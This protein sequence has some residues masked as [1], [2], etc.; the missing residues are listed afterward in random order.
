MYKYFEKYH[1]VDAGLLLLRLGLAA[2]FI[3]HGWAKIQNI[4]G[5]SGFFSTLGLGVFWVYL[6]AYV[7]FLGGLAMLIGSFARLAGLLLAIDMFFAIYLVKWPSG[8]VG[9]YEFELLILLTALT[10]YL[11]GPGKYSLSKKT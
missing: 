1:N 10:V 8:F 5:V 2:I 7:E 9:G 3:I 11:A 4:E 6:V